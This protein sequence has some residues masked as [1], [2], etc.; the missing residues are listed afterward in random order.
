MGTEADGKAAR[1][2][3]GFAFVQIPDIE[4]SDAQSQI[5]GRGAKLYSALH[6]KY[7]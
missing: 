6:R 4:N 7:L 1:A 2:A 3:M 5:V